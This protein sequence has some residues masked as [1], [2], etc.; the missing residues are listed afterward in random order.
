MQL[1]KQNIESSLVKK[2]A[3][4]KLTLDKDFNVPD[5]KEDMDKVIVV[6]GNAVLEEC[7]CLVDRVKVQ[8]HLHFQVLYMTQ[9]P[10]RPL[11]YLEGEI[12]FVE[13][14]HMEGVFPTDDCRVQVEL[15]DLTVSMINS[16]KIIAKALLGYSI[17][18]YGDDRAEVTTELENANGFECLYKK[19]T[20]SR[21]MVDKKDMF[22]IKQ[23]VELPQTKPNIGELIWYSVNVDS[24]DTKLSEQE[25]CL[26]GDLSLF[27]IYQGDEA[28]QPLQYLSMDLPFSGT[29]D[30]PEA[31][32]DMVSVINTKLSEVEVLIRPDLDGEE[33]K[34][35]IIASMDLDIQVYDDGELLLLEDVFAPNVELTEKTVNFAYESI[36]MKNAAKTRVSERI[37]LNNSQDKLM[38]I[39]QVEGSVKIDD[40]L[41]AEDGLQVEGVVL[42]TIIYISANDAHPVCSVD[43]MVPFSYLVEM[44]HLSDGDRYE[45]CPQL[46]Q[47]SAIMID[48]DEVE[49][50]ASVNL[51]IVAFSKGNMKGIESIEMEPLS[52]D[53]IKA[54]PA[55]AGYVVQEGDTLW[56]IAKKYYTTIDGIRKVNQLE[57]DKLLV[58]QKL[59]VV[60]EG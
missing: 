23:E 58:G 26:K 11:S 45:I 4:G 29:L 56:S 54:L 27:V 49:L 14:V 37:R 34:L 55:M 7:E 18:V 50:K 42:A 44:K 47:L 22:R 8:G 1:V 38:Q 3:V 21:K 15:E 39:C 25:I 19:L 16:R 35:E 43:A 48:G 57:S 24:L 51:N 36:I 33:R 20:Y 9:N 6:K 17:H 52:Y 32:A 10:E 41:V 60:K 53:K 5:L 46:E 28:G 30:L 12:P 59:L 40:E 31:T 13:S 2:E